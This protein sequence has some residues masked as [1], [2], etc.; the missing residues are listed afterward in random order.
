MIDDPKRPYRIKLQDFDSVHWKW[1]CDTLTTGTWN[2][3]FPIMGNSCTFYFESVEDL[4]AFKIKF[5]VGHAYD[6]SHQTSAA[7]N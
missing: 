5:G 1:C 7:A 6:S 2:A 4:L 3:A